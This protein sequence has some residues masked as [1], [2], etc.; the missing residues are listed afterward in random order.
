MILSEN[1]HRSLKAI[2]WDGVRSRAVQGQTH[3]DKLVVGYDGKRKRWVIARVVQCTVLSKFGSRTI[4]TTEQVPFVWKIWEDDD[5]LPL[6]IDDP[7][8]VSYIRRCDL[9]RQGVDKY[10]LQ[11]DK[12]DWLDDCAARSER[13]DVYHK[14]GEAFDKLKPYMKNQVGYIPKHPVSTKWFGPT[15]WRQ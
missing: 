6:S 15:K 8:L 10:M 14:A 13:D 9:W 11:F 2:R 5:G 12:Q 3:D 1:Q 4:P 7:R